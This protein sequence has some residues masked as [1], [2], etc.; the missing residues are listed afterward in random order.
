MTD[1]PFVKAPLDPKEQPILDR[2]LQIRDELSLL[3]S[4]KS[5]YVKSQDVMTIY[6]QINEQ[7]EVLNQIRKDKRDEQNRGVPTLV[8]L[9]NRLSC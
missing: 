6:Q 3:K 9:P 2:V 8:A 5:T 1:S 7:V 4:D